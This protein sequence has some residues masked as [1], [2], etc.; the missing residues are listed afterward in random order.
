[1]FCGLTHNFVVSF[2]K[3]VSSWPIEKIIICCLDVKPEVVMCQRIPV[4]AMS[5]ASSCVCECCLSSGILFY[6]ILL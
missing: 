3:T 1:M 6:D 2:D 4:F 5:F